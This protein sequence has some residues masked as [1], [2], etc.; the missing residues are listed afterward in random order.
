MIEGAIDIIRLLLQDVSPTAR[1]FTF[2]C[3]VGACCISIPSYFSILSLNQEKKQLIEAIEKQKQFINYALAI[4]RDALML[5]FGNRD[6]VRLSG[7]ERQFLE[8]FAP[9]INQ[10]NYQLL[11]EEFNSNFYYIERNAN[12]KIL[13]MDLLL[14]TN[15]YINLK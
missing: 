9:F 13:F 7:N 5:N 4:F 12:P 10:R 15:E 2:G 1:A 8:K 3:I 11:I 14:K 6:L